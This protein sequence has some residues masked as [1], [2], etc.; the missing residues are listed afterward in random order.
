MTRSLRRDWELEDDAAW[1]RPADWGWC[2]RQD[3]ERRRAIRRAHGLT[4]KGC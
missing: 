3:Y 4:R 1:D 2:A